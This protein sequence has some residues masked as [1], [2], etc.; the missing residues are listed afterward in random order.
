MK[1]AINGFGRIG[2]LFLR[3][4]FGK[5]NIDIVAINDLGDVDNL[6]YLL[7]HDTVYGK[8]DH[9]VKA[10]TAKKTITIDGVSIQFV[11]ERE[12]AKLPWKALSV[13]VV[14]EST[15]LFESFEKVR[16]HLAAGAKRVVIT[17]PAKDEDGV[18]SKTVLGGIN[19][20]DLKTITISSNGSCTTNSVSPVVSILSENPGI[21]RAML[22]TVHAYTAT[23]RIVDGPDGKDWRRGRAAAQNTVPSTTGAA[24][25]VTRVVPSL[26]DKFDGIAIRVPVPAGSVSD[27]TF[28]AK[29]PVTVQEINDILRKAATEPRWEGILKVSDDELV[30]SDIIGESYGAI[31]D[32]KFTRVVDGTLVKVLSWYDNEWGYVH[33]LLRHV[34]R[35]GETL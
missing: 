6:A 25:A 9:E 8:W 16:P 1:V 27:I 12:M 35:A 21:E 33:T 17:A 10:D 5:K 3:Q 14:V 11:Q 20:S 7:T 13:D 31:V 26:K 32:T 2:R 22:S 4:A 18:D 15:G 24:I 34:Q 23:Q 19:E 29:R 30:S 28:V